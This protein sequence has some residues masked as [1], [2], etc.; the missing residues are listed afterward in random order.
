ME[1]DGWDVTKFEGAVAKHKSNW[2]CWPMYMCSRYVHP[3][4]H[5]AHDCGVECAW[6]G[7]YVQV[8]SGTCKKKLRKLVPYIFFC[9]CFAVVTKS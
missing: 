4:N 8:M 2:L 5:T 6:V 7:I 9:F 3:D 1:V